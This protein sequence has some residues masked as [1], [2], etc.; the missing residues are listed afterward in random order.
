MTVTDDVIAET[1]LSN[2]RQVAMT[3]RFELIAID[4]TRQPTPLDGN[5]AAPE[6]ATSFVTRA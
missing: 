3:G 6:P 2:E 5:V 1:L 4:A